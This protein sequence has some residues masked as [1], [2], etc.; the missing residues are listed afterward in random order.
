[1]ALD[2]NIA[3]SDGERFFPVSAGLDCIGR[4]LDTPERPTPLM[5]LD[6]D[7]HLYRHNKDAFSPE[8][9]LLANVDGQ[10]QPL[11]ILGTPQVRIESFAWSW[12]L[13]AGPEGSRFRGS[14]PAWDVCRQHVVGNTT[15]FPGTAFVALALEAAKQVGVSGAT[16]TNIEFLRPLELAAPRRL[17]TALVQNDDG[18]KGGSIRFSSQPIRT[19]GQNETDDN[20]PAIVHCTCNFSLPAKIRPQPIPMRDMCETTNLYTR[21]ADAGF[22][23]GPAF[24]SPVV[25]TSTSTSVARC[26]FISH[27]KAFFQLHPAALDTAMHLVALLHPSGL[28]GVPHKLRQLQVFTETH[29]VEARAV[30]DGIDLE[31]QLLDD[32]GDVVCNIK[33][34][35]LAPLEVPPTLQL[36]ARTWRE[37]PQEQKRGLWLLSGQEAIDLDLPEVTKNRSESYD[38]EI[39]AVTAATLEDVHLCAEKARAISAR[40]ACW[41]VAVESQFAEAAAAAAVEMGAHAVIGTKENV[42][43]LSCFLTF[44]S[45][46]IVYA[47][48]DG[49]LLV[50]QLEEVRGV[51]PVVAGP[52]EAFVVEVDPSKGAK[53][54]KCHGAQRRPPAAHEVEVK[55]SLWAL[56]FRDVLVAVGAIPAEVAGQK[57]GIGGECYGEVVNVGENVSNLSVGD[58][59]VAV[60]PDG[61]GSFA[62]IDSQW[63]GIAPPAMTPEEAVSGT[64]V[65]ATAWLGLHWLAHISGGEKVLIHSAAGGVGLAAINLCLR[66]GCTV[67]ATA[68]TAE[69][70]EFLLSL[71]VA[72]AFDSR[73]VADF[74]DGIKLVTKGEG[75]DVVLNSL[76][77][78][79]IEASMR[80]LSPFGRFIEIGKRDQYEDTKVGLSPFLNGIMYAAAHLDVLM[81]RQPKRCRKLLEEVWAVMPELPKLPST[82]FKMDELDK[83]LEY[84][85]KGIHVGKLLISI[86]QQTPVHA[87][88]PSTILGPVNDTMTQALKEKLGATEG[89]GGVVCIRN[90]SGLTNTHILDGAQMVLTSSRAVADVAH[91]LDPQMLSIIL[92]HWEPIA[93]VQEWFGLQG[94]F[95]ATE[96]EKDGNL[97]EWLMEVV[98]E[99]AGTLR[100]DQSFESVGLDSLALISLARRLSAKI[101]KAV[102]VVDLYDNPTPQQLLASLSG[103][104][105]AQLSLPKVV[106]LHGFRTNREI[107]SFA[108]AHFVSAM[109]SVEWIFINAPRRASGPTDPKIPLDMEAYEWWGQKDGCY[110]TGWMAPH[111][112]GLEDTLPVVRSLAPSGIVGFSQGAAVA[113]LIECKWLALFSAVMPP[114]IKNRETP[115]FHSY[116]LAEDFAAQCA[117]VTSYFSNKELHTHGFG[118]TIPQDDVSTKAFVSFVAAHL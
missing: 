4:V 32:V 85:S 35:D 117:E 100:M 37:L 6:V 29:P 16:L 74:V 2:L 11:S 90:L 66:A 81:L 56:N 19:D 99:M 115:S 110:E 41:V 97:E 39:F 55:A 80:L 83:A 3:P 23:Y 13:V 30:L 52:S 72:A 64:A 96:E 77:G 101:G 25:E 26:E 28:N 31:L 36:R 50:E 84:F 109:G 7:W 112:D 15:I 62:T 42:Q 53:G 61:M 71:G 47:S 10:P 78:E 40:T 49:K 102:S 43:K 107:M 108:C 86:G 58:L 87:A 67:Y 82:T 70:R 9:P 54:A 44:Q 27:S 75:V 57:L 98:Q 103:G 45:P 5:A 60:P 91:S 95:V 20:A 46:S 68:S 105:Q 116:D 73:N 1:M 114:G 104:P 92:P 48:G 118:H 51:A 69:K 65:Y 106:C 89:K 111:F 93:N 21:F 12:E 94:R 22:H 59:V 113:T 24:R 17:M 8:D 88:H 38:A 63:V 14:C 18:S 76:S 79:A 34:L 33:G